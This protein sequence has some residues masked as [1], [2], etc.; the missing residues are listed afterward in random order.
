MM[1]IKLKRL[2]GFLLI[3]KIMVYI[4]LLKFQTQ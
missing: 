1:T 3:H 2:F 4:Y